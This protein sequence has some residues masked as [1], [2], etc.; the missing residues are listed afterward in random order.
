MSADRKTLRI[1]P[2][3]G[4]DRKT[5]D[6]GL[7]RWLRRAAALWLVLVVVLGVKS[8]TNPKRHSVFPLFVAGARHWWAGQSL[9]AEYPDV[10]DVFEVFRYSPTCALAFSPLAALPDRVGAVVWNILN[11]GVLAWGLCLAARD[12]LPGRWSTCRLALLLSLTFLGA[13]RPAW[14]GQSNP[15]VVGLLLLAASAVARDRGWTAAALLAAA[16]YLKVSPIALALLFVALRPRL[17]LARFAVAMLAGAALPFWTRPAGY[18]LDQYLTWFVL[19]RGSAATR[20]PAFRDAWTVWELT[21][22][23]V[24]VPT[25]RVL[26]AVAGLSTL[27]WCQGL[28]RRF[29]DQKAV[30]TGTLAMG[31]AYL[32]AFGPSVEHATYVVLAPAVA[33]AVLRAAERGTGRTWAGLAFALTMVLGTELFERPLIG[34]FPFVTAL[35]PAGSLLFAGWLVCHAALLGRRDAAETSLDRPKPSRH[36]A[37]ARRDASPLQTHAPL[38][39]TLSRDHPSLAREAAV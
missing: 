28:R 3:P 18:V 35:L 24:H 34:R 25:Y 14:N 2:G 21:G 39:A 9:Y 11:L 4:P 20:W 1:D 5:A 26:Q 13:I 30:L 37:A 31:S 8:A 17:L 29:A 27:A 23:A 12:V 22:H 10:I 32:M 15:L 7:C 38:L 16:V 19:L 6:R 36:D 33:W